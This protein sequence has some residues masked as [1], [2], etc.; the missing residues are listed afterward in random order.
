M[1]IGTEEH[2]TCHISLIIFY[3]ESVINMSIKV[4]LII[5]IL[6][7]TNAILVETWLKNDECFYET[8]GSQL[9]YDKVKEFSCIVVTSSSGLGKTVTMRHIALKFRLDGFEIVPIESPEDIIKYKTNKNQVFLID[10][11]LGKYD[12]NLRLLPNGNE[13]TKS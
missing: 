11:V 12:L 5:K 10:D 4:I 7:D 3:K 1:M 8:Y 9:V 6:T 13:S 2:F